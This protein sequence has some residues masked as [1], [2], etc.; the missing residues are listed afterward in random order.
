[1]HVEM[2]LHYYKDV[3]HYKLITYFKTVHDCN[4]CAYSFK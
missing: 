1:M 4:K 2:T 3:N